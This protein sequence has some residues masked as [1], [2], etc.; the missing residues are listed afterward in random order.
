[1]DELDDSTILA[2]QRPV[3]SARPGRLQAVVVGSAILTIHPLLK[4]GKVT[5]GRHGGSGIA[6]DHDTIS[7]FHA[8]LHVGPPHLIED[9]G[10]AN[11]ISV[12]GVPVPPGMKVSIKLGSVVKLGSIVLIVQTQS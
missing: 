12:D 10:S 9:V 11:G 8:V 2:H 3:E 6:I 5:I 4:P 7:R 1:M